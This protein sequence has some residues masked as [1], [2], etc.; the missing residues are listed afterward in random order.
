MTAVTVSKETANIKEDIPNYIVYNYR[1]TATSVPLVICFD[2][3]HESLA[4]KHAIP[5]RMR[6]VNVTCICNTCDISECAKT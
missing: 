3:L 1:P 4:I 6:T 2:R 5:I